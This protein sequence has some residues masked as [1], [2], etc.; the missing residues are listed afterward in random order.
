MRFSLVLVL[1][2]LH[3]NGLANGHSS[4][5]SPDNGEDNNSDSIRN[6]THRVKFNDLV[7][8]V[9]VLILDYLSDPLSFWNLADV[10]PNLFPVIAVEFQRKFHQITVIKLYDRNEKDYSYQKSTQGLS[11]YGSDLILKTFKKFGSVMSQVTIS[12]NTQSYFA[13][14]VFKAINKYGSE[15]LKFLGLTKPKWVA[16]RNFTVPFQNVEELSLICPEGIDSGPLPLN[17]LFP[18]LQRMNLDTLSPVEVM[19]SWWYSGSYEFINCKYPNLEFLNLN[20]GELYR[21][22]EGF[23]RNNQQIH[24]VEIGYFRKHSL[25][26]L[27]EELLPNISNLTLRIN[28]VGRDQ[29]EFSNVKHF[30]LHTSPDDRSEHYPVR[31]RF[32]RLES[33]RIELSDRKYGRY[34]EFIQNHP[35]VTRLQLASSTSVLERMTDAFSNLNEVIFSGELSV[36]HIQR[37]I[38]SLK[39]LERIQF[40]IRSRE[41]L[42]SYRAK[43]EAKWQIKKSQL[44]PFVDKYHRGIYVVLEKR[45]LLMK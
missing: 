9:L 21:G 7:I 29:I 32:P 1:I 25:R 36:D 5:L 10:Y 4:P 20:V 31:L 26:L 24:I 2:L 37:L 16:L 27:S 3:A 33:L 35:H 42:R 15:S 45:S 13:S 8:D 41:I 18:K 39:N 23:L 28:D 30:H 12:W 19:S 34:T 44:D 43:F 17:D 6:D 11:L 40:S 38:T 22:I 14:D